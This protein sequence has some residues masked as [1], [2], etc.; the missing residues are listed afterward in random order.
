[1]S[2]SLEPREHT[3]DFGSSGVH[4]SN[5]M[6]AMLEEEVVAEKEL[7][8]ALDESGVFDQGLYVWRRAPR[9]VGARL[10]GLPVPG[11]TPE[12]ARAAHGPAR[13]RYGRAMNSYIKLV[14]KEKKWKK[15]NPKK[16]GLGLGGNRSSGVVSCARGV[17]AA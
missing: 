5:S 7:A 14:A 6:T 2:Q 17:C 15:E 13:D 12:A 4:K 10:H 1:M 11:A 3:V 8:F 9:R 16:R